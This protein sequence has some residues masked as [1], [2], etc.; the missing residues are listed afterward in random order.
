MYLLESIA[1]LKEAMEKLERFKEGRS[2]P[3]TSDR[4][5]WNAKTMLEAIVHPDTKLPIPAAF[6]IC[7]FVPAQ[8]PICA[9]MLMTAPTTFNVLFWQWINQSYN[10]GFN[11]CNRSA[12]SELTNKD[13][14]TA[15]VMA[16]TVSCGIAYYMGKIA[17]RSTKLSPSMALLA[18]KLVPYVACSAAGVFNLVAMRSGDLGPGITVRDS[19]GEVLGRSPAAAWR[20]LALTGFTRILLPAPVLLVPP[21]IMRALDLRG[22]FTSAPKLRP[23]TELAV[24]VACVWGALPCTIG[25]F[26]QETSLPVSKLEVEFQGRR[27]R[28]GRPVEV[29]YFNRGV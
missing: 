16:T 3:G 23:V 5:L 26:P 2:L 25:L 12:G 24:I 6:R 27:T 9:G 22:L 19:D 29:I 7:A 14:A 18:Q 21:V 8:V 13:I 11:Y 28:D 4:D 17:E 20:A 10:A 1:S 15:Y